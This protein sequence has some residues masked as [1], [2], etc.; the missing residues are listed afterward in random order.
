MLPI[1]G[2]ENSQRFLLAMASN[3]GVK[4]H[5]IWLSSNSKADTH[6]SLALVLL[7]STSGSSLKFVG[8][9]KLI[10]YYPA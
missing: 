7:S 9:L 10:I 5:L 6:L 8:G 3:F 1:V 4:L 2:A